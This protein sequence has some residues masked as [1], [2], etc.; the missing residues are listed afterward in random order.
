MKFVT[1]LFVSLL[2]T[3]SAQVRTPYTEQLDSTVIKT[4]PLGAK[5]DCL[6]IFPDEVSAVLG[7]GLTDSP[8]HRS[9][10]YY[11]QGEFNPRTILLRH[12]DSKSI[13]QMTIM[14][15]HDAFVFHLKPD[16]SPASVV[17]LNQKANAQPAKEISREQALLQNRPLS[18]E[19]KDEFFRLAKSAPF[20]RD[21]IPQ[22]YEGFENK[23]LNITHRNRN[24][25]IQIEQVSR[26]TKNR[27][28]LVFGTITNQ[29][30]HS[31]KLSHYWV[32]LTT[33]SQRHFQPELVR[34]TSATLAPQQSSRFE[35]LLIHSASEP[36]LAIDNHFQLCLTPKS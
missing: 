15:G 8:T 32:T 11:E 20:Y 12:L 24:L 3:L 21:R 29:S 28:L 25:R 10:V 4:I 13:I 1:I 5:T 33:S 30:G 7:Q 23:K 27:A 31:I 19:R 17:Y 35:C 22:A 2:G 6:L 34:Y 36:P 14:L 18:K 26:F 16:E 9:G